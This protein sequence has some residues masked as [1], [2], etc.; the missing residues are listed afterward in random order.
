MTAMSVMQLLQHP[1]RIVEGEILL[2]GE[3]LVGKTKKEMCKIRG[4]D[5]SMI[6][7]EPMTSLN[8]V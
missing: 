6:F 7:Q 5:I 8:P 4:N 3:N 1:G 2:D